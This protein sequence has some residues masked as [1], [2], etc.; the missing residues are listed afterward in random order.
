MFEAGDQLLDGRPDTA[1]CD[2]SDLA[3]L[4][5]GVLVGYLL[6]GRKQ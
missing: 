1:G 2:E 3:A 6:A 4:G 5:V